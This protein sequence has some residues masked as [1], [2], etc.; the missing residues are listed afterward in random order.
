MSRFRQVRPSPRRLPPQGKVEV[1][2]EP[3]SQ[4]DVPAAPELPDGAGQIGIV[5]VFG[6][7]QAEHLPQ[8]DGHIAVTGEIVVQLHRKGGIP[9]QQH[10]TGQPGGVGAAD[11]R[12]H[13]GQLVGNQ[14]LF[15]QAQHKPADAL[16]HPVQAHPTFGRFRVQGGGLESVPHDGPGTDMGEAGKIQVEAQ[17]VAFRPDG[18]PVY[19]HAVA[20][21]LE[22]IK[23]DAQRQSQGKHRQCHPGQGVGGFG[24]EAG[25]LEEAQQQ[26]V[27][28]N[29]GPQPPAA[30]MPAQYQP[31]AP[32]HQGKG[33]QQQ[34]VADTRPGA[35][36]Q[37]EYP[38]DRIAGPRRQ[39]KIHCQGQRQKHK[40]K[41]NRRETHPYTAFR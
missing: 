35:E 15:A 24:Q 18:A 14:G 9:Q 34:A 30:G 7:G 21:A 23:A 17:R 12:V 39:H 28:G 32:V 25:V 20:D 19:I 37:T 29:H 41:L 33:N 31:E 16:V 4:G 5:K 3:G 40:Q 10:R 6:Q 13:Q 26:Q 27:G 36:P 1:V 2:P 8:A 22:G 38:Q 11:R